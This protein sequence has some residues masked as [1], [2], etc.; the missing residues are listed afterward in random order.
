MVVCGRK[1]D[2]EQCA[3]A[4]LAGHLDLSTMTVDELF[5]DR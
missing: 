4:E 3:L 2:G 5:H 1:P